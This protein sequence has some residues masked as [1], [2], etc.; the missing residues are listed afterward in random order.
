LSVKLEIQGLVELNA[1][2]TKIAGSLDKAVA[3]GLAE[4]AEKI[5]DDAK[6]FAPV[7]TGALQ[8]SIRRSDV[9]SRG[10]QHK[11]S[12]IAGGGG[13]INPKTGREVDYA[14]Y[15]EFGTSRTPPQPYM[16][17]A[18]EKNREGIRRILTKKILEA[19]S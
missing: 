5:K 17:P 15:Q 9:S 12:V 18:L 2:L 11:V 14:A 6:E 10:R 7:D 8:K 13:I 16:R 4:A 1:D 19:L 3:E